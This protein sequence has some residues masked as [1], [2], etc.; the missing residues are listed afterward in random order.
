MQSQMKLE[1]ISA[2]EVRVPMKPGHVDSAMYGDSD[3]KHLPKWILELKFDNGVV[4]LGESPRGVAWN[5]V[6]RFGQ[7]LLGKKLSEIQ[8]QRIYLSQEETNDMLAAKDSRVKSRR[9]EY[10]YPKGYVYYGYECALFDA[11]GKV[12][13]LPVSSLLGGA[14]RDRVATSFW[15]GRMTPDDAARQAALA[16]KLGFST[17]K[18]KASIEDPLPDVIGAMK[19]AAGE[20]FTI[21]IDPN[22]RFFRLVE[23]GRAHV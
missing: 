15:M 21:V 5:E 2:T 23:I 10:D 3:W 9:W 7:F 22:N 17:M 1:S 19:Q 13:G 14:F 6:E 8:F 18:M 20:P 4:G 12:S 16:R 11:W